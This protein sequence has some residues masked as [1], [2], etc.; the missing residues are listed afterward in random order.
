VFFHGLTGFFRFSGNDRAIDFLVLQVN[1][2][3]LFLTG[4]TGFTDMFQQ[5]PDGL[6]FGVD[7]GVSGEIRNG[8]MEFNV[9]IQKIFDIIL[10]VG[11]ANLIED[12]S[13]SGGL[14]FVVVFRGQ[15]R[16]LLLQDIPDLQD[17]VHLNAIQEERPGQWDDE[18]SSRPCR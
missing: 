4:H 6:D 18:K 2:A 5:I 13:Q 7:D 17:A 3:H 14:D 12:V 8:N 11:L 9:Q 10:L 1:L 16:S 15:L